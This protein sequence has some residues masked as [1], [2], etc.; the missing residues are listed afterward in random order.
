MSD[1]ISHAKAAISNFSPRLQSRIETG[2]IDQAQIVDY[3][4]FLK[5]VNQDLMSHPIIVTNDYCE[6][7]AAGRVDLL[8]LRHFIVQFSVFSNLFLVAQLH[9][10]INAQTLQTMHA[11][12][13][14]LANEL[15]TIF[16]R[17][18][19]SSQRD[20]LMT[21]EQKELSGDPE[22]VSTEGTVDGGVFRFKAAHFEWLLRIGEQLGLEFIDLGK[23]RHGTSAT[24]FFCDELERIYGN[25]D[26]SI[27]E[28]ASFA[29]E[30]WAAAGFWKQLVSG[31]KVIKQNTV[32]DL[33]L[34]FFTWH[35]R[36]E[37][38]H[39]THTQDELEDVYFSNW[40]DEEK[41]LAGGKEILAGV[42]EFWHGLDQDR[43]AS[44]KV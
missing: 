33:S 43:K 27:A 2:E 38:Q 4:T 23:R 37:E 6:W 35:D 14:I 29:V 17:G 5:Q 11:S 34:A 20:K 10:M 16:N 28:G 18:S 13:E 1:A 42:A 15:G 22:L 39:A 19:I 31:L 24:L 21:D 9:K 36:V 44:A 3:T 8:H 40:F 26:P 12:K 7:F 41:F 30:N 25:D 32:P